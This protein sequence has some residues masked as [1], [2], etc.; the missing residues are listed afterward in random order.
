MAY[1]KERKVIADDTLARCAEIVAITPGASDSSVFVRSQLPELDQSICPGHDTT[2]VRVVNGDSF[3]VA[4]DLARKTASEN[5]DSQMQGKIAVLNL[6][7]DQLPGGGW[8]STLSKT[9]VGS[10]HHC[11]IS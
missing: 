9:Q 7:S 8:Y 5:H 2:A 11:E 10:I 4:R 3:A 6:A 1:R